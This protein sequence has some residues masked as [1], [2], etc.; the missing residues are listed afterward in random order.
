MG[1]VHRN[2]KSSP[3]MNHAISRRSLCVTALSCCALPFEVQAQTSASLEIGVL[4]NISARTLLAQYQ[5]M[6]DYLAREL[7]RPVYISTAPNWTAFHQRTLARDYDVV[8]TAVNLARVAQ[9]D[10]G[11]TP[12]LSYAPNIRGMV[13]CAKNKPIASVAELRGQTLVLSNPQSLITL[14]GM[15]WLTE[16]GLQ[17]DKDFKTINTPTDDSVGN[18]VVRGDAL[19]AL[20]SGGEL[21][22][23]PDNVK[24]Q[25]QV[26]TTFAEVPGFVVM[27]SP[28]VLAA[29]VLALKASLRS[30]ADVSDEGKA[31]F[32]STGFAGM[33]ELAAGLLESMDPY[34][35]G[36][37]MVMATPG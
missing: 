33:R 1:D 14:R 29:D 31:F 7:K 19:A 27:A 36:T 6:R 34:V 17:R 20:L 32:A 23:I 30:F 15:Q 13:V 18:V 2:P 24:A 26:L 10:S 11:Y 5:P 12:L 22:A 4:P 28:K 16:N 21:R 9:L 37:R 25:L 3:P 35:A 8:V